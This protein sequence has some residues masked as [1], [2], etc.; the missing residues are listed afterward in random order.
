MRG[1]RASA[2][3]RT[4]THTHTHTE[5]HISR[6]SGRRSEAGQRL[7]LLRRDALSHVVAFQGAFGVYGKRAKMWDRYNT[8]RLARAYMYIYAMQLRYER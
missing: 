1:E 6:C 5:T 8:M 2:R 3:T 4:H 7:R